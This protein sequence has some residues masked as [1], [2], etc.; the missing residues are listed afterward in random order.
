MTDIA[1]RGEPVRPRA[2]LFDWDNTLIDSW[3]VIHE[4]LNATLTAYGIPPW[5]MEETRA[6][7]RHSMRDSFPQLFGDRWEEAGEF[8]YRQFA[9]IHIDRIEPRP[10][11]REMLAALHE[12]GL[13]L[14][15]VSNKKG[16]FLRHEANHLGWANYFGAI[17]GALDAPRD[18]PAREPVEMALAGSTIDPGGEVWFVGDAGIDLEC[19]A[20]TGCVPV[21]IRDDAPQPGEFNGFPP[22]WHFD[23]CLALSK[24]VLRL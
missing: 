4:S 18:K 2:V 7:V 1:E 15:V 3:P 21:L 17:V 19:A 20:N 24:R 14:G 12:A 23:N 5:T 6:R 13:Y 16:S 11:A 9:A 22:I 10:G 8:F